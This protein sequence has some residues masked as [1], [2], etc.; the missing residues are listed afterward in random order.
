MREEKA[1]LVD[2][3]RGKR[4]IYRSNEAQRS[5]KREGFWVRALHGSPVQGELA[6]IA[7]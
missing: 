4:A 3:T 6:A 2:G 1:L 7:D 5:V